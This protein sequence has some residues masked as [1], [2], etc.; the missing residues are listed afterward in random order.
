MHFIVTTILERKEYNQQGN[1]KAEYP[2]L[3]L[4]KESEV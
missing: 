2:K 1:A 3:P 4:T